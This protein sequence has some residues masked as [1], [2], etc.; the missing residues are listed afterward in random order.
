MTMIDV[1]DDMSEKA[2]CL[3][4]RSVA[5]AASVKLN[6]LIPLRSREYQS[7]IA[8]QS[9]L[10]SALQSALRSVTDKRFLRHATEIS[11]TASQEVW[12]I[13]RPHRRILTPAHRPRRLYDHLRLTLIQC[14]SIQHVQHSSMVLI[15]FMDLTCPSADK[16][17]RD[18]HD[19]LDRHPQKERMTDAHCHVKIAT[20]DHLPIGGPICHQAD[21]HHNHQRLRRQCSPDTPVREKAGSLRVPRST[22]SM[23]DSSKTSHTAHHHAANGLL[24][25]NLPQGQGL[26]VQCQLQE[27]AVRLR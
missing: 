20:N 24:K 4:E 26:E 12:Q 17:R 15:V 22:C 11:E 14:L 8:L 16:L 27:G 5:M 21:Q 19:R 1:R 18:Y 10:Q 6:A 25:Q 23:A 9:V 3:H 2:R 7:A 13:D